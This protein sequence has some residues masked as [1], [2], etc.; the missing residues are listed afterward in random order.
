[1]RRAMVVGILV[2]VTVSTIA[3]TQAA[4]KPIVD[5]MDT[6]EHLKD[7]QI[8]E[9]RR[10]TTKPGERQHFAEYFDSFFPEAFEQLG[11]IAFGQFYERRKRDGFTWLRGFHTKY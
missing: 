2:F 1:M 4:D 11:A 3:T 5:P 10:Y 8:I 6:V 9:F 7:F